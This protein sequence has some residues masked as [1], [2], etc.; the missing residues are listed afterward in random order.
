M[1]GG[2]DVTDEVMAVV[3]GYTLFEEKNRYK[4]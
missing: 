3:A 4:N 1:G 2:I